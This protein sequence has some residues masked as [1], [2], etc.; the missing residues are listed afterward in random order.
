MEEIKGMSTAEE[1]EHLATCEETLDGSEFED[2]VVLC[3]NSLRADKKASFARPGVYANVFKRYKDGT[4]RAKLIRSLPDF[5]GVFG[6]PQ[7]EVIF[8]CKVCSQASLNLS[9]YRIDESGDRS[10]QLKHMFERADF[11]SVC[12]MLV[13][14]NM[15]E[16][17]TKSFPAATYAMPV[18]RLHPFWTDF[19]SGAEKS[20]Q[21]S[22][23]IEYGVEVEWS[24]EGRQK[25]LR[26]ILLP[27]INRVA[28]TLDRSIDRMSTSISKGVGNKPWDWRNA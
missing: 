4:V 18:H 27:T 21:R 11:G 6:L 17:K 3:V 22:H 7:R 14:W 16:L 10:R 13:H 15:R 12:F 24:F 25:I 9:K 19:A 20:L 8:D 23:C 5:Q 1:T 26:P 2:R 28:R